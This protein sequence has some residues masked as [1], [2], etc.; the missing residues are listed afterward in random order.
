MS[1]APTSEPPAPGSATGATPRWVAASHAFRIVGDAELVA[2]GSQTF[3]DFPA[4]SAGADCYDYVV[5][6]SDDGYVV[7]GLEPPV[8]PA[9]LAET[10]A[11]IQWLVNQRVIEG[12][13]DH[14]TGV[15]AACA[16][17]GDDIVLIPAPSGSGKS[18]TVAG[19]VRAGW[20]YLTDETTVLDDETL[21]VRAY[22]K[23]ITIDHGAWPLF[24]E[25]DLL[26]RSADSCL[27][28]LAA[29][30]GAVGIGGQVTAIVF[31]MF[32]EGHRAQLEP[33]P[34]AEVVMALAS[35]TFAFSSAGARHLRVLARLA[36]SVS[37]HR[38]VTGDLQ[39]TVDAIETLVAGHR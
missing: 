35:S 1:L 12:L 27:V 20:D 4:A 21:T 32:R 11:T 2:T 38:L 7:V 5:A 18:T 3:A 39:G 15:H 10:L 19:L 8:P 37:G 23:P 22:P 26:A 14:E 36:R 16:Q 25:T 9:P 13:T 17:R 30:G 29:L 31:P 6:R 24:P 34:P 33:M 28:P